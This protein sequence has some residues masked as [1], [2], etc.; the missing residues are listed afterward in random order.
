[1]T[2]Q[3]TMLTDEIKRLEFHVR[4]EYDEDPTYSHYEHPEGE[5]VL[6]ADHLA[7]IAVYEARL[8]EDAKVRAGLVEAL[9]IARTRV[10]FD[11]EEADMAWESEVV[12]NRIDAALAAAKGELADS[13]SKFTFTELTPEEAQI[14]YLKSMKEVK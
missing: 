10:L 5:Y 12:I 14:R 8:A 11:S 4:V 2:A 3:V 6:Y 13:R 1:M 9:N 7:A